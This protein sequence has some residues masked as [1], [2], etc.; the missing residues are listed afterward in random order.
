MSQEFRQ[1]RPYVRGRFASFLEG[2]RYGGGV[3]QWAWLVHRV[4]GIGIL[5]YLVCHIIDTFFVIV[6]PGLYDQTM[7]LYAG[8]VGGTLNP[9]LRWAFRLGELGL[10]ACVL[11]HAL[12]GLRVISFDF[13]PDAGTKH[14][15][16]AFWLVFWVFLTVMVLVSIWM[17]SELFRAPLNLPH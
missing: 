7:A 8:V 9:V 6:N 12:N 10:F 17:I 4:T 5:V 16:A 15:K 13:W 1:P 3:G 2:M 14:Q 11:F